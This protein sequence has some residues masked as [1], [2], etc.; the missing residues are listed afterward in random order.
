MDGA[1][2]EPP[3]EDRM[4]SSEPEPPDSVSVR[5]DSSVAPPGGFKEDDRLKAERR[6]SASS[7]FLSMKTDRSMEP[8]LGF[9]RDT[10]H[11]LQTETSESASDCLSV[12][13]EKPKKELADLPW[14]CPKSQSNVIKLLLA[15]DS[16]VGKTC[17]LVRFVGGRF[18][19][20]NATIGLSITK[21]SVVLK[22]KKVVLE[23][24]DISGNKGYTSLN[25]SL[26]RVAHGIILV[27]DVTK[28][29][30]FD[31]L[32]TWLRDIETRSDNDVLKV[33]VANKTDLTR[34]REVDNAAAQELASKHEMPFIETSAY[35]G[36]AVDKAF[37]I[38]ARA[39]MKHRGLDQLPPEPAPENRKTGKKCLLS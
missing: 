10:I 2:P 18:I 8:P 3:A 37:L 7:G 22:G 27:Y 28:Q 25:C 1:E 9:T 5:G 24:C 6:D 19:T 4:R 13:T 23:M 35:T 21:K 14:G 15:G 38:L 34:D 16:F 31:N 29:S 30:S 12:E 11:T 26:Y 39:V 20:P 36:D 17:L 33:L 32:K